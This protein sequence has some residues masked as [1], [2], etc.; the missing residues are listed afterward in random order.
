MSSHAKMDAEEL[1]FP[2]SYIFALTD[3]EDLKYF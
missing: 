3:V 2:N 1:K